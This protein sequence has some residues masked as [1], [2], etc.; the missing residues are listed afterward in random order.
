MDNE[1]LDLNYDKI[2][3]LLNQ[4]D[5]EE[6]RAREK[7]K[8][9]W[10]SIIAFLTSFL[11]FCMMIAVW[12]ILEAGA[13]DRDMM[14]FRTFFT[15]HDQHFTV[16]PL[17]R[18]T[19]NKSLVYTAYVLQLVSLGA[20]AIASSINILHIKPKHGKFRISIFI[21]SGITVTAFVFFMIRFFRI[22]F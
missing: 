1:E 13:P 7:K 9:D 5:E 3:D 6:R 18:N 16:D 20:C 8:K 10:K 14:F 17:F 4:R 11:A 2:T 15:V 19:W 12:V 22:I 21:I